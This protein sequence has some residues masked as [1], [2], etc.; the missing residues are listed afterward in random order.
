M[1]I[2]IPEK[3]IR[4]S[5]YGDSKISEVYGLERSVDL[6]NEEEIGNIYI[7]MNFDCYRLAE[8]LRNKVPGFGNAF[9]DWTSPCIGLNGGFSQYVKWMEKYGL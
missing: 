5:Y 9:L 6:L 8:L 2:P 3:K 7:N 4:I 1:E